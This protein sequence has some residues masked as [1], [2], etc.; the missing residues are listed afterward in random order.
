MNARATFNEQ[1][2]NKATWAHATTCFYRYPEQGMGDRDRAHAGPDVRGSA[3]T[4]GSILHRLIA[5]L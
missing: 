5:I 1:F 4:P 3:G 2:E